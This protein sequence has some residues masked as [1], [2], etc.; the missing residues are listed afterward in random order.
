[1]GLLWTCTAFF[2]PTRQLARGVS[3]WRVS[4]QRRFRPVASGDL[5]WRPSTKYEVSGATCHRSMWCLMAEGYL[6][7]DVEH[8]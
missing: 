3:W 1:M 4:M 6:W 2:S 5:F 8:G 7:N